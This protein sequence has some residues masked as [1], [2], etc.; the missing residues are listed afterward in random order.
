MERISPWTMSW[1]SRARSTGSARVREI[2]LP[3]SSPASRS[4]RSAGPQPRGALRLA[5]PR[6]HPDRAVEANRLAV[7]H[8]VLDDV[9]RQR[10]KFSGPAETLREGH[11]LAEGGADGIGQGR[12]QRRVE[13]A[14]GDRHDAD[15]ELGEIACDR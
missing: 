7:Q 15:P 9:E 8:R 5:L 13:D 11:L 10:R 4:P 3:P 2:Q 12:E 1:R 6:L 14:G